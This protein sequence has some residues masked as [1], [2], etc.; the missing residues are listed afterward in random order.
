MISDASDLWVAGIGSL[1]TIEFYHSVRVRLRRG[2]VMV[3][4]V[5]THSLPPSALTLLV[6]TFHAAFPHAAIWSPGFGNVL[7]VGSVDPVG[8]DSSRLSRSLAQ[9][10]GVREDLQSIGVWHP[11]ALFAAFVTGEEGVARMVA[12]TGS[13]HTDDF[14]VLEF[15]TPRWLY[16]NTTA[17]IEGV[18]AQLRGPTFPPVTGFDPS[19][20]LDADATYLL[21]FA[22]ASFGRP[23]LGIPFMERSVEMAPH[24]AAFVVGLANQYRQVGCV[25]DAEAAYLKAIALDPQQVEA[26]VALGELLL[27]YGQAPRALALAEAALAISPSDARAK[28]LVARAKP[29]VRK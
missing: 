28:A 1:F 9:I 26:R 10:P 15:A 8:W 27:E 11:L 22:Y 2:G 16:T 20:G 5:H 21:G 24:R 17:P 25:A 29:A 7:L 14:P 6:A 4:W 3:Q 19:R 12:G 18:L 13:V 23:R